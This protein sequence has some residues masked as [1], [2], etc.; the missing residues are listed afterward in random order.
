VQ[1]RPRITYARVCRGSPHQ[2]PRTFLFRRRRPLDRP[3]SGR[4]GWRFGG[5][6]APHVEHQR[7]W[8]VPGAVL[9][10]HADAPP[11]CRAV[12]W[13]WSLQLS[14][15][16][17]RNLERADHH[18]CLS[19]RRRIQVE[20]CW[21]A[22]QR[23]ARRRSRQQRWRPCGRRGLGELRRETPRAT[24]TTAAPAYLLAHV[25]QPTALRNLPGRTEAV[26]LDWR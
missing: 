1:A 15:P 11:A 10:V 17:E 20:A 12:G 13:R 23:S 26:H 3:R 7:R 5:R 8:C 22:M 4:A 21:A 16:H 25:P 24:A 18:R 2:P 19:P 14:D 9:G 6:T